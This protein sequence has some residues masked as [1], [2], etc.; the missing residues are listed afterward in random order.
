MERVIGISHS[1]M[2]IACLLVLMVLVAQA[3]DVVFIS[4]VAV[5]PGDTA[6]IPIIIY[7]ATGVAA[8]CLNLSYDTCV[9]NLTD[10]RQGD[11][12]GFFGFDNR[13]V[14]DGWTR[15][16]TYITCS[17]LTG[18]L[19][20]VD[21]TLVAV[22]K[23]G[24]VSPLNI[25]ILAMADQYGTNIPGTA[26]NGR[27]SILGP[28]RTS[29]IPTTS[30]LSS[31]L[32][33]SSSTTTSAYPPIGGE[34][35]SNDMVHANIV[36]RE[37]K[38]ASASEGKPISHKFEKPMNDIVYVNFTITIYAEDVCTIVEVLKGTS[39]SV[40]TDPSDNVYKN[41]NV[42]TGLSEYVAKRNVM[43]VNITFRVKQ[44]WINTID[45]STV[46]LNVYHD[47]AWRPL[48]T[49]RLGEDESYAYYIADTDYFGGFAIT[50]NDSRVVPTPVDKPATEQTHQPPWQTM[51][52]KP[53]AGATFHSIPGFNA[54]P[55]LIGLAIACLL[56]RR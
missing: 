47:G 15:I 9:V 43:G 49:K 35:D 41:V 44:G 4:N 51:P 38:C 29:T 36:V 34:N 46:R 18:D 45:P 12:T 25:E 31:P 40:E 2:Q 7:D 37:I 53:S 52:A 55:G 13:N 3:G 19:K 42:M 48:K 16:N 22:G 39:A 26:R 54:S 17:D 28:S 21:V 56:R 20:V 6:T 30:T 23:G 11:F 32:S 24:A 27:F 5:D 33:S 8:V 10:A 50:A 1:Y 14:T